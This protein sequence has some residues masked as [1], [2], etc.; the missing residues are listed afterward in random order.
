MDDSRFTQVEEGLKI[1]EVTED[2]AGVYQCILQRDGWGSDARNINVAV[3]LDSCAGVFALI[4]IVSTAEKLCGVISKVYG[5]D[6]S[7]LCLLCDFLL[8]KV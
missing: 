3:M 6:L 5:A 4:A 8:V 2:D 7:Q 1:S